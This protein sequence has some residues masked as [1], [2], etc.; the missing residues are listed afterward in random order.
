MEMQTMKLVF[1]HGVHKQGGNAN[2]LRTRWE[3]ALRNAWS[4]NGIVSPGYDL[5]MPLYGDVL[6]ELVKIKGNIRVVPRGGN[7]PDDFNDFE[8]DMV[9]QLAEKAGL[10]PDALLPESAA[11]GGER[12]SSQS[13]RVHA[14][15]RWLC[16]NAPSA[17][18]IAVRFVRQVNAY[19]D[20]PHIRNAV[21][22]I[23]GPALRSGP[24]VVVAHCLGSV[25]AY[26]LLR[27]F[28]KASSVKLF[29]TL[30]SPLGME[31]VKARL[32]PPPRQK[33]DGVQNWLNGSD[34]RDYVALPPE[35]DRTTFAPKI[36]NLTTIQNGRDDPHSILDYLSDPGVS[37]RIAEEL[38]RGQTLRRL[39]LV[40]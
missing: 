14:A 25:I 3:S 30:G 28:G 38:E 23:V 13:E 9:R 4:V 22:A 24:S 26:K 32:S 21:D 36:E 27:N 29:V 31:A 33:P 16:R 37:R 40:R 39:S 17:G 35:L 11:N 20:A 10:A 6:D 7:I 15:I 18:G 34:R 2:V 19:L 12:S 1:I 5:Q 8:A